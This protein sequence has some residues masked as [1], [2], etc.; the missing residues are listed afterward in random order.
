VLMHDAE[1]SVAYSAQA[2]PNLPSALRLK[3]A[4]SA[5]PGELLEAP[6]TL[7]ELKLLLP[8]LNGAMR[9]EAMQR[10]RQLQ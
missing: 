10:M 6:L 7:A 5:K 8:K 2:N 1:E 3:L 4:L 9:R